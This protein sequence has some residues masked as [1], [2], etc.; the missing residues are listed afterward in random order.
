MRQFFNSG[1][2]FG[3]S[4]SRSDP[5][6]PWKDSVYFAEW[7]M[8][9][10][11]DADCAKKRPSTFQI[12]MG[13]IPVTFYWQLAIVYLDDMGEFSKSHQ[14]VS[15]QMKRVLRFFIRLVTLKSWRS[16]DS[17]L[18][19]PTMGS[20]YSAWPRWTSQAYNWVCGK[21]RTLHYIDGTLFFSGSV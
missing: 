15:E 21:T 4:L 19:P 13:A 18:R 8:P 5:T 3:V 12:A 11:K 7:A 14:D 17:S 10:N 2:Y 16:A 9:L 20:P 1:R 6:R